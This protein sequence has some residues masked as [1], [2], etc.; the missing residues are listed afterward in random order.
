FALQDRITEAV[1]G[2]IAPSIQQAEIER[3]Q[4]KPPSNLDAY[5]LYLRATALYRAMTRE[6]ND[7]A[8]ALLERAIALD[9][10][11]ATAMVLLSLLW[12]CRITQGW[13]TAAE[14]AEESRKYVR[15]AQHIDN[16][17]P[18]VLALRA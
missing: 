16:H 7:A 17:N 5:D 18:D 8:R 10:D 6:A 1:A 3:A 11:Y 12:D 9:P 14:V 13:S 2:A 15:L 4:R